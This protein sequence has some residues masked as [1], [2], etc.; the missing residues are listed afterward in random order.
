MGNT[1]NKEIQVTEE[2]EKA[3]SY[4]EKE[5]QIHLK[6]IEKMRR[7]L[8]FNVWLMALIAI[9]LHFATYMSVQTM[10]Q[11]MQGLLSAAPD[12][13]KVEDDTIKVVGDQLGY[14][15]MVLAGFLIVL[16]ATLFQIKNENAIIK[17]LRKKKSKIYQMSILGNKQLSEMYEA[18][19]LAECL[20]G[21]EE[22]MSDISPSVTAI[23]KGFDKIVDRIKGLTSG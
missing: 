18:N 14:G 16:V 21:G 6:S 4:I 15:H 10:V 12:K 19:L 9:V 3:A 2:F 23:E 5:I 13:L 20:Q 1:S 8:W 11:G 17:D 22:A 7:S